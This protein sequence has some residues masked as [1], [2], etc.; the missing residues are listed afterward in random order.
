MFPA[1]AKATAGRPGPA[2]IDGCETGPGRVVPA[3]TE[4]APGCMATPSA[5]GSG[6]TVSKIADGDAALAADNTGAAIEAFSGAITLKGDSMV[7]YSEARPDLPPARGVRGRPSGT[8]GAPSDIDPSATRPLE[9]LG[10]AYLADTPH[11]YGSAAEQFQAYVKLDNRAPRILYKLAFA[12]YNEQRH[13][14]DV[15]STRC[16]GRS[17]STTGSPRPT[18]CSG[19][20]S[21]TRSTSRLARTA[22]EKSDRAAARRCCTRA[23][24]WPICTG[25]L[26]TDRQPADAARGARRALDPGAS[27]EVTLGLAYARAG[28]GRSRRHD[29]RARRRALP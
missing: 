24:S 29:A 25:A 9:E 17:R 13:T 11:R 26:G 7:G 14:A 22:L 1:F 21:A 5:S 15:R 12:R 19:S 27:R 20:A 28:A 6:P 4:R 10:D 3:R 23:R 16:S 2:T 18:T 8:S